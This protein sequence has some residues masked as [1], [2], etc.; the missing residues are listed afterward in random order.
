MK[1]KGRKEP[2]KRQRE[3]AAV[4]KRL[5]DLEARGWAE[6]DARRKRSAGQS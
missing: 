4:V 6:L 1:A 2:S 5:R 3:R